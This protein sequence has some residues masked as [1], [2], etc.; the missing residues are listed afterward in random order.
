MSRNYGIPRRDSFLRPDLE[1]QR[2]QR[3]EAHHAVG[4]VVKLAE[5]LKLPLDKLPTAEVK[6]IHAGYGDDWA[7]VFNLKRAMAKRTGTGM[8][9]PAQVKKQLAR[10]SKL[11][12]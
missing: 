7:I 11:L 6:K 1:K 5:T 12:G 8:P 3:V 2:R 10:W 4:S 9:G